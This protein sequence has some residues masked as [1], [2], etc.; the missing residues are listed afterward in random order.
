[1]PVD[2]TPRWMPSA[3]CLTR[4]DLPWTTD[5]TAMTPA[6]VRAMKRVCARC[7]VRNHCAAYAVEAAVTGGFWA[8]TDRDLLAP[9]RLNSTGTAFQPALLGMAPRPARRGAA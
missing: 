4:P 1:M 6:A 7:P 3:A 5:T 8:G 2:I 9:R